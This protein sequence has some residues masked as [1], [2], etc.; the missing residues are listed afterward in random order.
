MQTTVPINYASRITWVVLRWTVMLPVVVSG[1][2]HQHSAC[3]GGGRSKGQII[4]LP[5]LPLECHNRS[6]YVFWDPYHPTDA[7]NAIVAKGAFQG[8]LQAAHPMNVQQL[9]ET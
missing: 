9:V 6:Q 7:F 3:C 1:F 4:C 8:T 2:K 5:L